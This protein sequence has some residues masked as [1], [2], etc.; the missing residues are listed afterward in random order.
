VPPPVPLLGHLP[1][2]FAN[3]RALF[4]SCLSAPG[5]VVQL[6][7]PRPAL[8]LKSPE[9]IRHVLVSSADRYAKTPRLTSDRGRRVAGEGVFTSSGPDHARQR[10]LLRPLFQGMAITALAGHF[11]DAAD[12]VVGRWPRGA[13]VEVGGEMRRAANRALVRSLFGPQPPELGMRL[14]E[15]FM[16]RR[17]A[18]DTSLLSPL[19][20]PRALPLTASPRRSAA[21]R[22]LDRVVAEMVAE[23]H[24]GEHTGDDLLSSLAALRYPDGARMSASQ[25]REEVMGLAATGFETVSR[26]LAAAWYEV[27]RHSEVLERVREEA[28]RAFGDGAPPSGGLRALPYTR[29]VVAETLRLHPPT[30]LI[31]R[32]AL[33]SDRLPSGGDVAGGAKVIASPWLVQRDP[34]LFPD[35]MRFVPERFSDGLSAGSPRFGYFPFGG[36]SRACIGQTYATLE[37]ALLLARVAQRCRLELLS[38]P[39]PAL[40]G[41]HLRRPEGVRV[42]VLSTG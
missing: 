24:R 1:A 33:E 16:A 34:A 26:A 32:H 17:R 27:L 5:P 10:R 11:V 36:G 23:R 22:W 20:L 8:V 14:E 30:W 15:A 12:S 38:Q 28:G 39:P 37:I 18:L 40:A 21:I 35:P 31:W 13:E 9:D 7:L 19:S 6:R 29:T 2:F 41:F 42:R 3:P 4:G 25:L